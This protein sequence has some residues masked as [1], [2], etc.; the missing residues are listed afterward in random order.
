[1]EVVFDCFFYYNIQ[2]FMAKGWYGMVS[3]LWLDL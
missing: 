3:E 2:V 1:M